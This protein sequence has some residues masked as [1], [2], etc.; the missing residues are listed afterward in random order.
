MVPAS[1]PRATNRNADLLRRDH[2]ETI[3]ARA[4]DGPGYEIGDEAISGHAKADS[5]FRR[6]IRKRPR[7]SPLLRGGIAPQVRTRANRALTRGQRERSEI[8]VSPLAMAGLD[9]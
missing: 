8:S 9:S 6:S 5:L 7:H 3:V 1:S 2:R 4:N